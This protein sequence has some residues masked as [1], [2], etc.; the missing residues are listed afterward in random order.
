[1]EQYSL[2]LKEK[3]LKWLGQRQVKYSGY[4]FWKFKPAKAKAYPLTY[5]HK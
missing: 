1:M 4:T 3:V 5:G 2:N